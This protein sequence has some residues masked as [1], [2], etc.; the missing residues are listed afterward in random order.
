QGAT[1][2]PGVIQGYVTPQEPYYSTYP[3]EQPAKPIEPVKPTLTTE[4]FCPS[5]GAKIEGEAKFCPYCGA[6][7]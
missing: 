7:L 5:C 4:R 6:N 2:A 3:P 1:P